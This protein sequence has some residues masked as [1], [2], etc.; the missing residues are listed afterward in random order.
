MR[1]IVLTLLLLLFVTLGDA[2]N[3]KKLGQKALAGA[4]KAAFKA[5]SGVKSLT[6]KLKK[7]KSSKK[8]KKYDD[9]D[10]E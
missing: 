3:L 2:L 1:P 8:S 10:D 7:K 5:G 9:D 4:A 6:K